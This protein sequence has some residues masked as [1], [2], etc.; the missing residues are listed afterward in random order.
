MKKSELIDAVVKRSGISKKE[1]E[2]ALDATFEE[3]GKMF[4]A[5]SSYIIPGFGTFGV[6]FQKSRQGRNFHTGEV[7]EIPE[8]Y[9]PTFKPSKD[10][11]Q[12]V[13]I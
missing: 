13:N 8:K 1:A 4:T 7:I 6:K 11:M 2:T 9:V 10:L 5:H 3:L 12:T